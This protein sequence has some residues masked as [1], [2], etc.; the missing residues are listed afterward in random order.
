VVGN[1]A[2]RGPL[3]RQNERGANHVRAEPEL[4]AN[5]DGCQPDLRI[6]G[7]VGGFDRSDLR[8]G[9]NDQACPAGGMQSEHVDGTPLTEPRIGQLGHGAPSGSVQG[10]NNAFD[11]PD[12]A[13]VE[14]PIERAAALS[15][16][17]VAPC[18]QSR[19][20]RA[21]RP[22]LDS[23]NVPAFDLG[24]GGLRHA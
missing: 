12:M 14:Q 6:E 18:V 21:Q 11:E 16:L 13:L 22:E 23:V 24:D 3:P 9:L 5:D 19:E 1:A 17:D 15:D 20:N 7:A 4:L 8:L 2:S 10:S